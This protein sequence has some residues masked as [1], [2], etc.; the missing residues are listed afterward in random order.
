VQ[1][2]LLLQLAHLLGAG[3]LQA[4]PHEMPRAPCPLRAFV[5][6]DI[7]NLLARAVYGGGDHSAH[8]VHFFGWRGGPVW[9]CCG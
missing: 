2:E 7:G 3:L 9:A 4:D 1:V 5:E 6:I 8:D